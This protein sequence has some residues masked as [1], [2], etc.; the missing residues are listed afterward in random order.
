MVGRAEGLAERARVRRVRLLLDDNYGF[1]LRSTGASSSS[2]SV[3]AGADGEDDGMG[4]RTAGA[5]AVDA[6][7]VA[8]RLASSPKHGERG[9]KK[10]ASGQ[11]AARKIAMHTASEQMG[12][13]EDSFLDVQGAEL[14]GDRPVSGGVGDA[15]ASAQQLQQQQQQESFEAPRVR[16]NPASMGGLGFMRSRHGVSGT[17]PTA[18]LQLQA[19]RSFGK[20][21]VQKR[22]IAK[23]RSA[24][25]S[26]AKAP[27]GAASTK[28]RLVVSLDDVL[29][30]ECLD[31]VPAHIPSLLT[32]SARP[33]NTHRPPLRL[34]AVCQGLSTCV[35]IHCGTR[36]CTG[37]CLDIHQN[38]RC[39]K[40]V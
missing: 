4:A 1:E 40:W 36:C 25:S 35:C 28:A 10:R 3:S 21:G 13:A 31:V 14:Q 12:R 29:V 22:R 39:T 11:K 2:A 8:Q 7:A 30:E 16:R 26:G 33:V 34:C 23:A 18:I 6:A 24:D 37:R 38:T 19:L 27:G 15:A 9:R 17:S 32:N 5:A 20:S